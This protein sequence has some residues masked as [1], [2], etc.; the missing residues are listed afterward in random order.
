MRTLIQLPF[1]RRIRWESVRNDLYICE[2]KMHEDKTPRNMWAIYKMNGN[3]Y[4]ASWRWYRSLDLF[5]LLARVV[6]MIRI[7]LLVVF[8]RI[9]SYNVCYTKLLREESTHH[10]FTRTAVHELHA[11][12]QHSDE[13][14]YP[15][16]R[17]VRERSWRYVWLPKQDVQRMHQ[18]PTIRITSYNVCY[19]KLL[20]TVFFSISLFFAMTRS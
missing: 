17:S 11:C 8:G 12:L 1:G 18:P 10:W 9:T 7:G 2:V 20:R 6:R 15:T 19:T 3:L 13:S 14:R 16:G 4:K 5:A